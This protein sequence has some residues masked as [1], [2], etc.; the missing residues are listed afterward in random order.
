MRCSHGPYFTKTK[1]Y[2]ASPNDIGKMIR[3]R[4]LDL[5]LRQADAAKAIGCD[6]TTIVNWENGHRIPRISHLSGVVKFLGFDPFTSGDT[7]AQRLV[8]HRKA[9][10]ATQAAFAAQLGVDPSPSPDGNVVSDNQPGNLRPRSRSCC[11]LAS[12]M[13]I[14]QPEF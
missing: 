7:L 8:N 4:R 14:V 11:D 13:R 12:H 6:E 10:G 3:K 1:G 2:P 5:E 9:L